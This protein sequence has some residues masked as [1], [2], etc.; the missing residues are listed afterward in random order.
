MKKHCKSCSKKRD[1][2]FYNPSGSFLCDMCKIAKKHGQKL[3]RKEAS[4]KTW[5]KKLDALIGSRVRSRG[6][7]EAVGR[8][9]KGVL[10]WA[11]IVSRSY[12]NTRW[13]EDNA[14]C[15]CAGCHKFYTDRPLEWGDFVTS[16]F[17]NNHLEYLKEV[18][19]HNPVIKGVE[20]KELYEKLNRKG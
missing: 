6:V 7:C 15:L 13:M 1:L 18:A 3:E 14:L 20:L 8:P 10:Q 12:H 5:I 9:H 17:G 16:K 4:S 11:H 19:L 2:K